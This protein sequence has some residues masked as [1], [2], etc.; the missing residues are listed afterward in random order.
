MTSPSPS[1]RSHSR[2]RTGWSLG[3]DQAYAPSLAHC[4]L[5]CQVIEL[6]WWPLR[7]L[8]DGETE[9]RSSIPYG[10][11]AWAA[12]SRRGVDAV[13]RPRSGSED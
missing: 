12:T 2:Q 13:S 3:R 8:A 9:T 10:A 7:T 1:R 5:G 11:G 6:T 4:F